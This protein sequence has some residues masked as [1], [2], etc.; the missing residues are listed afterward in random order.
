MRIVALKP[1][2]YSGPCGRA[3]EVGERVRARGARLDVR[4]DGPEAEGDRDARERPDADDQEERRVPV[5]LRREVEPERQAED[6]R[7]R[8]RGLHEAHHAAAL[9][10]REDVG[11]DRH[12]DRPEHAA[13]DAGEDAR[14]EQERVAR[15]ERAEQRA[16]EE[17]D[18]E[19][20]QQLLPVEP[21]GEPCGEQPRQAGAERVR[22]HDVAELLG[23]DVELVEQDRPEG[24]Q[25]HEVED[26][27]EVEEGDQRDDE[28]LIAREGLFHPSSNRGGQS[29]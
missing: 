29:R 16:A 8:E 18:V 11:D 19:E 1:T 27:G 4:V 15:R 13:E 5:E 9:R 23:R 24:R 22:R 12:A 20:Q 3:G 21:I 7:G 17:A 14:A 28:H 6:L 2:T 26:D 10:R 25:D